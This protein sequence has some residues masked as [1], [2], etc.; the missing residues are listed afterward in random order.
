MSSDEEYL[1]Q[2]LK[3]ISNSDSSLEKQVDQPIQDNN[4]QNDIFSDQEDFISS[5]TEVSDDLQ[6]LLDSLE[7]ADNHSRNEEEVIHSN[8][9]DLLFDPLNLEE[10]EKAEDIIPGNNLEINDTELQSNQ[11]ESEFS[12]LF[13]LEDLGDLDTVLDGSEEL[14][15]GESNNENSEDHSLDDSEKLLNQDSD[16]TDII[17]SMPEDDELAEIGILLKK[18]DSDSV[19]DEDMFSFLESSMQDGESNV[20]GANQGD[21][22]D[23]FADSEAASSEIVD[24]GDELSALLEAAKQAEELNREK[25]EKKSKEK[26]QAKTEKN[27]KEIKEKK[28]KKSKAKVDGLAKS[29]AAAMGKDNPKPEKNGLFHKILNMLFEEEEEEVKTPVQTTPADENDDILREL[30]EADKKKVRGKKGKE[31]KEGKPKKEKKVKKEKEPKEK[32][33]KKE[34]P[35]TDSKETVKGKIPKKTMLFLVASCFTFFILIMVI[36]SV[37]PNLLDLT[38]ARKAFYQGNYK[39]TYFLLVDKELNESDRIMFQKTSCI[40]E[41]QRKIDSYYNFKKMDMPVEALDAV[42][43][44]ILVYQEISQQAQSLGIQEEID[45]KYEEILSII[46][47]YDLTLDEAYE[48]LILSDYRYS[49]CIEAIVAGEDYKEVMEPAKEVIEPTTFENVLPEEAEMA[50]ETLDVINQN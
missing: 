20:N 12:D 28:N 27:D 2:L 1:D 35:Q 39:D 21:T 23:I 34:K 11:S 38:S 26:K 30:E 8:E 42:M 31:T 43:E 33:A 3:S 25:L 14:F 44:G 40:L 49:L 6:Q 9:E 37:I 15:F 10:S 18:N 7:H 13:A 16:I 19:S 48:I 36:I 5:D 46:G 47:E 17:D 45:E 4:S 22:F 32:K 50:E 41:I 24:V 29:E